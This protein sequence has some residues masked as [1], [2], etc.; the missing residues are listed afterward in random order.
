MAKK[1]A[2][3][4]TSDED[5]DKFGPTGMGVNPRLANGAG[6]GMKSLPI[7]TRYIYI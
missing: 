6:V 5:K 3:A 2:K 4:G 7:G 1:L